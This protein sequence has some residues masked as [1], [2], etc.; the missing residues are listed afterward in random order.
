MFP[1]PTRRPAIQGLIQ[2]DYKADPSGV[3][4]VLLI[5]DIAT[6][7]SRLLLDG[8]TNDPR[9]FPM[10]AYYGDVGGDWDPNPGFPYGPNEYYNEVL[11]T[12]TIELAVGRID[13]AGFLDPNNPADI[14][15][16]NQ[17]PPRDRQFEAELTQQ[18]LDRDI[19]FRTGQLSVQD[20][21]IIETNFVGDGAAA[22]ENFGA[23]TGN[24]NIQTLPTGEYFSQNPAPVNPVTGATLDNDTTLP[25]ALWAYADGGG[26]LGHSDGVGTSSD[27]FDPSAAVN[28]QNNSSPHGPATS[29]FNDMFG[30]FF[31]QWD[32][33]FSADGGNDNFVN[34]PNYLVSPLSGIPSSDTL[35]QEELADPFN[36]SDPNSLASN[37]YNGYG[38]TDVWG[39][40][41]AW[42]FQQMALGGTIGQ[43][44]VF[45]QNGGFAGPSGSSDAGAYSALMG[46][47]TLTQDI[48]APVSNLAASASN[49]SV[50]LTWSPPTGL[51]S[52]QQLLGYNVYRS[53]GSG[54]FDKLNACPLNP[55]GEVT[56]QGLITDTTYTDSKGAGATI[57][58]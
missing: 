52:D 28:L 9:N 38:L 37:N 27:F 40:G 47:P 39:L 25:G 49:G 4:Q 31:G 17:P 36:L 33:N 8:H 50:T 57:N 54:G 5:G 56:G 16:P 58:T 43:S 44:I 13:F 48:V 3:K 45:S 21:A 41:T 1:N 22:F 20:R 24:T 10:D 34:N 6:P 19:A 26:G 51:T 35:F 15:T 7:L 2:N 32:A 55:T 23:L 12:S 11:G 14:G 30:S 29:V 46:D 42:N 53:N 18:Y